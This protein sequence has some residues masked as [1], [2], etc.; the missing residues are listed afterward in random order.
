MHEEVRDDLA[1]LGADL[2]IKTIPDYIS[3]KITPKPQDH[4]QATHTKMLTREDGKIDWHRSPQE[5]YNQFRAYGG[6]PGVWFLHKN[7]RVK[8]I[9]C[10]LKDNK[11]VILQLQ[12]EGGRPMVL[13]DFINGYG[14]LN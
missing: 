13:K 4:S 3:G 6:W 1:K 8:I 11:L 2:L 10:L 14:N 5:I 7:K 9:D 12:P